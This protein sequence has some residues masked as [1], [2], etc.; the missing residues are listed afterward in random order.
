MGMGAFYEYGEKMRTLDR[1]L[2]KNC[3]VTIS[4]KTRYFLYSFGCLGSRVRDF[5]RFHVLQAKKLPRLSD[6]RR[7]MLGASELQGL[8]PSDHSLLH[9]QEAVRLLWETLLEM[10]VRCGPFNNKDKEQ[11]LP[12]LAA[13]AC[14]LFPLGPPEN[15]HR[16]AQSANSSLGEYIDFV[17]QVFLKTLDC[18]I[19]TRR[20][21][22]EKRS[23]YL[24][25]HDCFPLTR[26]T[27]FPDLTWPFG[28]ATKS[29]KWMANLIIRIGR[30]NAQK[31]C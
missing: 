22:V 6:F 13:S 3:V 2:P 14:R 12:A 28:R 24:F 26:A 17:R 27:I 25:L 30:E 7:R 5:R 9:A 1:N 19:S 11:K 15:G 29:T 18:P 20:Y 10:V 16:W 23:A 8:P 4:D 31:R 21:T